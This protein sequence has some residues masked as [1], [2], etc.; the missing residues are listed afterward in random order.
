MSKQRILNITILTA[1]TALSIFILFYYLKTEKIINYNRNSVPIV[2]PTIPFNSNNSNPEIICKRSDNSIIY[3]TSRCEKTKKYTFPELGIEFSVHEQAKVSKENNIVYIN[4]KEGQWVEIIP[5]F[6]LQSAMDKVIELN[7]P[8]SSQ[9][10]ITDQGPIANATDNIVYPKTYSVIIVMDNEKDFD[11]GSDNLPLL[12]QSKYAGRGG[13]TMFLSDSNHP[14]KIAFF[15][16]G[17]Y[18]EPGGEFVDWQHTF[19]FIR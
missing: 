2:T 15:K 10:R 17:Q 11:R 7:G 6:N 9:C 16:I 19:R 13:M 18:S 5:K 3:D 8:T 4:G 1:L 12:C 14:D